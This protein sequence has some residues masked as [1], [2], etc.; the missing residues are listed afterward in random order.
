MT[1]DNPYKIW[2]ELKHIHEA[3]GLSTQLTAI[4]KFTCLEKQSNQSMSEWTGEVSSYALLMQKISIKLKDIFTVIALT[5]G[6]SPEYKSAVVVLNSLPSDQLTL[7]T[8]ITCLLNKECVRICP[9]ELLTFRSWYY[10]VRFYCYINYC[11]T[12]LVHYLI[13]M[14]TS[15]Y[16]TPDLFDHW[17]PTFNT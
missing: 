12:A 4:C 17:N 15:F 5:S 13:S 7:N 9:V 3:Q 1:S 2:E 11:S 8:A 16:V 14:I 10:T 6:L